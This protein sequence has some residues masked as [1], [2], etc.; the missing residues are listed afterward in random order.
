[1]TREQ[2]LNMLRIEKFYYKS[3]R[4]G[5]DKLIKET[6]LKIAYLKEELELEDFNEKLNNETKIS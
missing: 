1:M 2:K 4:D 3:R 5:F 6:N